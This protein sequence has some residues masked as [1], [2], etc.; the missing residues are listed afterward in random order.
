MTLTSKKAK[1]VAIYIRV[2]TAGQ[3]EDGYSIEFQREKLL[4]YCSVHDFIV[5][6][7]YCDPGHSGAKLARPELQ[8][9]I[10]DVDKFDAVIVYKLDR[11][12]RSQKDTLYLIEDVFLANN[13]DFIS[14]Q[15]SFDTS[16]AF[17]VAMVGILSV[18]AQL[19]R[20]NIKLRTS[21]GRK[22]RAANGLFH[23]GANIPIGYD[24]VDGQ[25]L[26]NEYEAMMVKRIFKLYNNGCATPTIAMA[27]VNDGMKSK[28]GY[29]YA[30][31]IQDI[32]RNVIYIG[33]IKWCGEIYDGEHDSIIDEQLFN[34][35]QKELETRARHTRT[36]RPKNYFAG[37]IHCGYCGRNLRR[38]MS[39]DYYY[40][41][42]K[43]EL[44]GKEI[45]PNCHAKSWQAKKIETIFDYELRKLSFDNEYFDELIKE[46]SVKKKPQ[47]NDRHIIESKIDEISASIKKLMKLYIDD[48]LPIKDITAEIEKLNEER[49]ILAK[50]LD[51]MVD[52]QERQQLDTVEIRKY[53]KN[54][55]KLWND[56]NVEEKRQILLTLVNRIIVFDTHIEFEWAFME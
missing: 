41:K 12:S 21:S 4:A 52:P 35:V 22:V 3:V 28:Y 24:Y 9:L 15:E 36:T 18:F 13:I 5:H 40:Y 27:L 43:K 38:I 20:E 51:K 17:G 10:H 42:C 19:E 16:T 49:D 14:I 53:L 1:R 25:L 6:D 37:V 48:K 32:L 44:G 31:R 56:A 46:H 54:I 7:I 23:G 55:S 30:K 26:I 39:G 33:K 50:K 29:L 47:A 8:R 11:L 45:T 34:Q 2:S